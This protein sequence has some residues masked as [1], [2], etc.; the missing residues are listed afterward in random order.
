MS[1]EKWRVCAAASYLTEQGDVVIWHQFAAD[2][3][4]GIWREY[5]QQVP[6]DELPFG[7][8]QGISDLPLMLPSPREDGSGEGKPDGV[9]PSDAALWHD[10]LSDLSLQMTQAMFAAWLADARLVGREGNRFVVAL[11]SDEARD[12]VSHRLREPIQRTLRH[13][14]GEE[15]VTVLFIQAEKPGR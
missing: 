14:L 13:A 3:A 10:V 6:P 11:P 1:W 9:S 4:I 8:G 15:G 5:Y 2:R 7:V 12:W